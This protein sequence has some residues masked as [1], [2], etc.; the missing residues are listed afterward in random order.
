MEI[1][2]KEVYTI[3]EVAKLL[4]VNERMIYNLV[5]EEKIKKTTIGVA[6]KTIRI[7]G[8]HLL[9]YLEISK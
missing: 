9:E 7:T 5:S 1:N 2:E 4:K 8:K 3:K 6:G